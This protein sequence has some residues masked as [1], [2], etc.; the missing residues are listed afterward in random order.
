MFRASRLPLA[1]P[2]LQLQRITAD[3]QTTIEMVWDTLN[4]V[5]QERALRTMVVVCCQIAGAQPA[6]SER[7]RA[8]DLPPG[9]GEEAHNE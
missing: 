3:G 8:R 1:Q 2:L 9:I 5:Q 4:S 6:P 7:I